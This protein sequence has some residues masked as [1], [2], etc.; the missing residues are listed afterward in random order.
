MDD[1]VRLHEHKSVIYFDGNLIP[2]V[3]LACHHPNQPVQLSRQRV[4]FAPALAGA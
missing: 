4:V 2:A 3:F 1:V